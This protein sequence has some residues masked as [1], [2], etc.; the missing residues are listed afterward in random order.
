MAPEEFAVL[1]TGAQP[2]LSDD[3][4]VS[5]DGKE[6]ACTVF[7]SLDDAEAFVQRRV[8]EVPTVRCRIYDSRGLAGQ[9][10]RE[11]SGAEHKGDSEISSRF[12][13]WGAAILL[14]GGIVLGIL[15]WQSDFTR[16]WPGTLAAR[17]IP[18]GLILLVTELVIV[19]E[20][21]RKKRR[22]ERDGS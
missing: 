10:V 21:R 11:I 14:L 6:S 19:I 20:A 1:Y 12:R 17:M 3:G 5:W 16:M 13:R 2:R 4:G 9:P 18:V 7:D 15:D 22:T 8:V